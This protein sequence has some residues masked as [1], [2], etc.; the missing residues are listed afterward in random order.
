MPNVNPH[1]SVDCVIIGFDSKTLKVL[2]IERE[3]TDLNLPEGHK[4]KLPGN[5]IYRDEDLDHSAIRIL[6][7]LTGLAEYYYEAICGIF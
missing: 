5:M 4:L 3:E 2:L 7:E 6:T 1:I